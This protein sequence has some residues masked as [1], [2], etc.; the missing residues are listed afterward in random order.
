MLECWSV[1][2]LE[3]WDLLCPKRVSIPVLEQ[4][5]SLL[6]MTAFGE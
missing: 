4:I 2:V 3:C 5:E 1:G 6:F